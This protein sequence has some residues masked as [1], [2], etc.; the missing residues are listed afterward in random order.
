MHQIRKALEKSSETQ[1][2]NV[3]FFPQTQK[4]EK[5]EEK[6]KAKIKVTIQEENKKVADNPERGMKKVVTFLTGITPRS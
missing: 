2:G 5:L 6:D 4:S 3:S 1:L